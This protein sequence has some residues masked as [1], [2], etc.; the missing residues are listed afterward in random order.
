[1]LISSVPITGAT[2]VA[3]NSPVKFVFLSAMGPGQSVTW[4]GNLDPAKFSFSWSA[5]KKTITYQYGENFQAN[6]TYTWTANP[7]VNGVGF[8]DT[9]GA[10]LMDSPLNSGTFTT[11]T[12]SG[13]N[14]NSNPCSETNKAGS[15][16]SVMKSVSYVQTS[17][18]PPSLDGT[19][20]A[21]FSA[22]FNPTN[23]FAGQVV[24]TLP[25]NTT[26][27]L[28]NL[29]GS[30]YLLMDD[31]TFATPEAMDIAYIPG[32]YRLAAIGSGGGTSTL[33]LP[34]GAAPNTPQIANYDSLQTWNVDADT[35]VQW[36]AFVGASTP[37]CQISFSVS[38]DTG[39]VFTAPDPCV[40]RT[41]APTDTSILVP[42]NTL[43]AGKTY[44]A[45]LDFTKMTAQDSTS[46][47]GFYGFAA[48]SKT[49]Q[50][51]I[52]ATHGGTPVPTQPKFTA[53][54]ILAD[55]TFQVVLSGQ[56]GVTYAIQVSSDGKTWTEAYSSSS[57]AGTITW[58]DA[59]ALTTRS[60]MYRAVVR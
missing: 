21:F 53:F 12:S 7:A 48:Y 43:A 32:S 49:T 30:S 20:P 31:V 2:D 1:M 6:T 55:K 36:G 52:H 29:F 22:M 17:S 40:P 11:G 38:D 4:S 3:L 18:A 41:L 28:S 57:A 50:F 9:S 54:K 27:T 24:L 44:R 25:D 46:I 59:Q 51:Q 16:Y 14:T 56:A 19:E 13:G 34:A 60:Q 58:T 33:S 15:S 39:T 47:P 26:K 35:T 23:D 8:A 45:T 10:A 37:S 42:K 5:D